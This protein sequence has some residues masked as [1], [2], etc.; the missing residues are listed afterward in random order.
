MLSGKFDDIT[1]S[2]ILLIEV[3][4]DMLIHFSGSDVVDVGIHQ[5]SYDLSEKDLKTLQ[6]IASFVVHKLYVIFR[7]KSRKCDDE[8]N[9]QVT[10]IL[11]AYKLDHDSSQTYVNLRD[12]GG[13][14]KVNKDGQ[15]VFIQCE[16][17]F[18]AQTHAFKTSV[19]CKAIVIEMIQ[20]INIILCGNKCP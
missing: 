20:D 18:R 16:K 5:S 8:F 19:D 1:L 11:F 2:N 15:K 13:L 7:L 17:I 14:W 10:S 4:N 12:R 6:Y 9:K 3:A